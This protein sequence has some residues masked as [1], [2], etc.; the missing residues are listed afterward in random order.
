M[1]VD[2]GC[3]LVVSNCQVEMLHH[4]RDLTAGAK[5]RGID[6]SHTHTLI[7]KKMYDPTVTRFFFG[8]PSVL[9]LMHDVPRT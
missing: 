4:E 3:D 6:H 2:D 9:S 7:R 5:K 8:H 1:Q